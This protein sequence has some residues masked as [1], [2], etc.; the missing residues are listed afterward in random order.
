[1]YRIHSSFRYW[2]WIEV[3]SCAAC[4]SGG[5]GPM[6]ICRVMIISS[7]ISS[8]VNSTT[9]RKKAVISEPVLIL[10]TEATVGSRSSRIHG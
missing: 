10:E 3:R 4:A 1:M 6:R 8:V 2:L 9:N 5:S 7:A